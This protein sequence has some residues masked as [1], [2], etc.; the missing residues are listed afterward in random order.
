MTIKPWLILVLCTSSSRI[1]LPKTDPLPIT[2]T[3]HILRR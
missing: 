1:T 3:S 2:I